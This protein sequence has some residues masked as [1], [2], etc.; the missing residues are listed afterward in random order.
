MIRIPYKLLFLDVARKMP[1]R[2]P[3]KRQSTKE[4]IEYPRLAE[5]LGSLAMEGLRI[6]YMQHGKVR[7]RL[8]KD[9]NLS[10]TWE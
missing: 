1:R 5:L 7:L 9:G 10:L 3:G 6:E 4:L 8:V 2:L